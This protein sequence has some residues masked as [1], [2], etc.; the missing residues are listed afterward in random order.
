VGIDASSGASTGLPE[1]SGVAGNPLS[2]LGGELSS[3]DGEERRGLAE[4]DNFSGE[5]TG[6]QPQPNPSAAIRALAISS[7]TL[8]VGG[9]FAEIDGEVRDNIAAFERPG[10]ALSA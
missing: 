3:I 8:Y 9:S 1:V 10:G 4:I 2:D 5:P 6:W 7:S